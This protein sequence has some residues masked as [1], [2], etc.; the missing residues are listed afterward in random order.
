MSAAAPPTDGTTLRVLTANL[1]ACAGLP[2]LPPEGL[3]AA[4]VRATLRELA[5]VL[6]A[7]APDVIMAQELDLCG[8]RTGRVRQADEL[9]ALLGM[10][11]VT[12]TCLDTRGLAVP[13]ALADLVYGIAL[14][15]RAP[16]RDVKDHL[17]PP[18][19][20]TPPEERRLLVGTLPTG[21]VRVACAHLDP[22]PPAVRH[23]QLR[24]L[25]AALG[26]GPVVLGAD[27]NEPLFSPP[28]VIPPPVRARYGWGGERL[29]PGWPAALGF[30]PPAALPPT[31]PWPDAVADIDHVLV[32][33]DGL[34]V[35]ERRRVDP[36]GASDHWFVCADV[37]LPRLP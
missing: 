31:W 22:F 23:A 35:L 19:V 2:P 32:R 34:R 7:E 15:S 26:E 20:G 37:Q 10:H 24:A 18:T 36:G 21:G 6:A 11:V 14:F 33:G 17:L 30:S 5:A 8:A 13:D 25:A 3:P 12:A 4:T 28:G 16:L 9:A 29:P 1:H 27:L